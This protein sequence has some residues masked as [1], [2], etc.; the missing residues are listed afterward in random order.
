PD[1]QGA[2]AADVLPP[3]SRAGPDA[4]QDLRAG[5]GRA[6]RRPVEHARGARDGI[7]AEARGPRPAADPHAPRPGLPVRRAARRRE[8]LTMTLTSRL[9]LF[10][11]G[12]LVMVLV[13]FS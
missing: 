7:E 11:T 2:V 13:G 5:L 10:F 6:I 1:R 12:S 4:D 8:G 9:S 3:P